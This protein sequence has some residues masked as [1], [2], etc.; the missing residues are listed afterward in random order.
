MD[1]NEKSRTGTSIG[2]GLHKHS[3]WPAPHKQGRSARKVCQDLDERHPSGPNPGRQPQPPPS[4]PQKRPKFGVPFESYSFWG[5]F[6]LLMALDSGPS[7]HGP[8]W[9]CCSAAPGA[10]WRQRDCGLSQQGLGLSARVSG[11]GCDS[12]PEPSVLLA[13]CRKLFALPPLPWQYL[14]P[15]S[16]CCCCC[17]TALLC[18][19]P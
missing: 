1:S 15:S 19:H 9:G 18:S 12:C 7:C 4:P 6:P 13:F 14:R 16:S 3:I 5:D 8:S 10:R 2:A 11:G 17:C